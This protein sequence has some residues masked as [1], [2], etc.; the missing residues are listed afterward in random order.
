MNRSVVSITLVALAIGLVGCGTMSATTSESIAEVA[1][2]AA[3]AGS[4]EIARAIDEAA[5]QDRARAGGAPEPRAEGDHLFLCWLDEYGG[6][7]LFAPSSE[8]ARDRCRALHGQR[9]EARHCRC[10]AA[11]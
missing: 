7:E 1:L 2:A 8:R 11:R 5:V 10:E 3:Q 9:D 4:R 6:E